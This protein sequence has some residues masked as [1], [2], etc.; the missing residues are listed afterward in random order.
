MERHVSLDGT[1][2]GVMAVLCA[3]W[4]LQQV[5]VKV[6]IAGVSPLLQAG[7]R[8]AAAALLVWGWSAHRRI[9]L[10][11]RDG[12]L[13]PGVVA[14]LLFAAEFALIFMGLTYTSASR[15]VLFLY[16]A[17]FF[18]AVGAHLFLP[19]ERLGRMQWLGLLCAF[20]GIA[21]AFADGLRLPTYRELIGDTMVLFAALFWAA[22]TI[23]IRTSRLAVASP[24]KTLLYQ[25]AGSAVVLPLASVM[26]G[27]AGVK[28]IT[29]LVAASLLYQIVLV[30][31][32]SYLAWLWLVAHYPAAHLAA[33]SFLTPLFGMTAGALLLGEH[34]SAALAAAML[35][36]GAGIWLVNRPRR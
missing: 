21:V 34:V 1:A 14:A 25:L 23:V 11:R 22:T 12:T 8:S 9:P 10:F 19:G 35:M 15:S 24:S 3:A 6:A 20:I 2:M 31:F 7:V 32:V 18:V 13:I 30:A 29:P 26:V 5:A 36:V 4:G 27:E 16:T 33:F 28:A 17:P